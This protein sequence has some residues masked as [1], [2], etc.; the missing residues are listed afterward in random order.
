MNNDKNILQILDQSAC[1]RKSQLLG[2]LNKSLYPEELRAVELHL[3]SCALCSDAL[4]G[5]ETV[6][7]AEQLIASIQLPVLPAI[8]IPEKIVEKK[9]PPAVKV[10]EPVSMSH[11]KGR[12]AK[13]SLPSEKAIPEVKLVKKKANWGRPLGIAAALLIGGAAL[14]YFEI[15]RNNR[16]TLLVS[17]ESTD[18]NVAHQNAMAAPATTMAANDSA[19]K[20]LIQKRKDSTYLAVKKAE[21]LK[22]HKDS[23][24]SVATLAAS[25]RDSVSKGSAADKTN[26]VAMKEA[27]SPVADEAPKM[28]AAKQA[29]V[30]DQQVA[31]KKK[32]ESAAPSSDYEMGMQKY[33][34]NNFASAL[35]YFKTAESDEGNP[36]HWEAVYYSGMCNKSL[37]KKRK[38][39]KLFERVVE[40]KAPL[41][42]AAQKQLDNLA[43]E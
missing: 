4:E 17:N 30:A 35:L 20:I 32:D 27:A 1:L 38:A 12:H 19:E 11:P 25:N 29:M 41:A 21:R 33:K 8:V 43:E 10:A 37:N 31:A 6:Q 5:M 13:T 42:K 7:N 23:M 9:E 34:E 18:T 22:A 3:S 26:M 15:G 2:Y 28:S 39:V 16:D 36:K 40:A 24:L 14:W